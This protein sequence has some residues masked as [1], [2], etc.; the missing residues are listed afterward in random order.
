MI[1]E[2]Q[3]F[4]SVSKAHLGASATSIEEATAGD[5][6]V[7]AD[8]LPHG[9]GAAPERSKEAPGEGIHSQENIRRRWTRKRCHEDLFLFYICAFNYVRSS[10]EKNKASMALFCI[11]EEIAGFARY[12]IVMCVRTSLSWDT[13]REFDRYHCCQR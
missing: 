9:M 5:D 8:S 12:F 11:S 1:W 4:C 2:P 7:V 13:L 10:P 3:R 6:E